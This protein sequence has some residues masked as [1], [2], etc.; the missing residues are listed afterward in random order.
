MFWPRARK[1]GFCSQRANGKSASVYRLERRPSRICR[2]K[3][4]GVASPRRTLDRKVLGPNHPDTL[5]A[6]NNLTRM[7]ATSDGATI[8]NGT[9]AV[10]LAE[11]AVAATARQNRSYLDTLAAA[12][13]ETQQFD[14]AAA[15]EPEPNWATPGQFM[16]FIQ[17][18]L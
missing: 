13:A 5:W 7:P 11:T 17:P 16:I 10:H 18:K 14:K 9:N 1:L 3:S 6:M 15:A 12:Y 4:A 2:I 8:R